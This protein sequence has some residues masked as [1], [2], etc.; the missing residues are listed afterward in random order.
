VRHHPRQH[1]S[2]PGVQK[3]E[4][5]PQLEQ[6]RQPDEVDVAEAEDGRRGHDRRQHLHS[7]TEEPL[8]E[9]PAEDD[10]LPDRRG[11]HRAGHGQEEVQPSLAL[12]DLGLVEHLHPGA[13]RHELGQELQRD[14]R[15][16]IVG[17]RDAEGEHHR[18]RARPGQPQVSDRGTA[19]PAHERPAK[20]EEEEDLGEPDARPGVHHLQ[21]DADQE[22]ER[23]GTDQ[24]EP[25]ETL[26]GHRRL[27]R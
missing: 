3:T 15:R 22:E 17:H 19:A 12:E 8:E 4:H 14:D 10:L 13:G 20:S 24:R 9:Q 25:A 6:R 2:R 27:R 7:A 18:P 26:R 23:Q 1:A 5:Q 11:G 16:E 21:R